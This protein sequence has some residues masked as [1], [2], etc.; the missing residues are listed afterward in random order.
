MILNI[1]FTTPSTKVTNILIQLINKYYYLK[2]NIYRYQL[3]ELLHRNTNTIIYCRRI[4]LYFI[5]SNIII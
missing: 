2:S 5:Q 3:L 1:S 4:K